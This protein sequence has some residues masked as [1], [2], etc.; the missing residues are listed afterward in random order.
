LVI[1]SHELKG[2]VS[3]ANWPRNRPGPL[4][5]FMSEILPD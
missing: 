2:A 5:V 4:I 3:P 1:A